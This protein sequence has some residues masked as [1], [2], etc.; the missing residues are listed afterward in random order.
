MMVMTL[1]LPVALL[2]A[3]WGRLSLRWSA[4]KGVDAGL[5]GT[6]L[7]ALIGYFGVLVALAASPGAA[8]WEIELAL[9][10]FGALLLLAAWTDH[11]TAWAPDG[12]ILPLLSFGAVAASLIGPL[13][14]GPGGA[15]ATSVV[16]FG[17]AQAAWAAQALSGW[18]VLPPPDLIALSLPVLLFGL[19]PYTFLTY[20]GLSLTLLLALKAPEPV[21]RLIRGPAAA[22]AVKEAAL[23][24][25]GRSAPFLPMALGAIYTVLLLRLFQG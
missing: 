14:V 6:A 1:M 20:L 5:L 23:T 18:R 24:G 11:R 7:S 3:G 13:G 12:V 25:T 19:T 21:Y 17:V 4:G 22:E 2:L 10:V 8:S 15:I 16:I 9:C